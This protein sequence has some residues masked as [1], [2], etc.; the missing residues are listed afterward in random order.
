MRVV[1]W[2]LMGLLVWCAVGRVLSLPS[3]C[4][5]TACFREQNLQALAQSSA[6]EQT[7]QLALGLKKRGSE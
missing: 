1:M 3:G 6:R 2:G 7:L 4:D 5:T